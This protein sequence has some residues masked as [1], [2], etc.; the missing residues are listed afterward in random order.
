MSRHE[1][2]ATMRSLDR[3]M[4]LAE[5]LL[6]YRPSGFRSPYLGGNRY[7][8]RDLYRRLAQLGFTWA[9][10]REIRF[11]EELLRPWRLRGFP[12]ARRLPESLPLWGPITIAMNISGVAAEMLRWPRKPVRRWV[13]AGEA[14]SRG[15]LDEYPL[16]APMDCDLI[17]LLEPSTPTPTEL[18][19]YAAWALSRRLQGPASL[20][21]LTFH[22]WVSG[23]ANRVGLLD[24]ALAAARAS[25]RSWLLPGSPRGTVAPGG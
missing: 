24:H 14:F 15:D 10:N 18:L 9:S 13:L 2:D 19:D 7:Y 6:G 12:P 1:L 21:T 16:S 23:T 4:D 8:R 5:G 25:G 22:D 20:V 11:P 17:G 3:V